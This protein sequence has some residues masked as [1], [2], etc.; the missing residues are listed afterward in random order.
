MSF[1]PEKDLAP[2]I[3]LF[4][5]SNALVVNA[6]LNVKTI[7]ELVALAK[8]KPLDGIDVMRRR[9]G[10]APPRRTCCARGRRSP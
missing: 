5:N 1:N 7:P 6:K 10:R 4:I 9:R 3:N 8:T 2:I